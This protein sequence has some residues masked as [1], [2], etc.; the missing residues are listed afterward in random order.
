MAVFGFFLVG[1]RD[2]TDQKN[3]ECEHFLCIDGEMFSSLDHKEFLWFLKRDPSRFPKEKVNLGSRLK[4]TRIFVFILL[5][6]LFFWL[7]F[8]KP[9]SFPGSYI[10]FSFCKNGNQNETEMRLTPRNGIDIKS[11][12]FLDCTILYFS[13]CHFLD[14]FTISS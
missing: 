13:D 10:S 8:L 5:L 2:N 9:A 3:S 1:I 11:M 12:F 4:L 6:L 14:Q 7:V